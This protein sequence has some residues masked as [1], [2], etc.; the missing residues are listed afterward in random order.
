MYQKSDTNFLHP[1]LV[2]LTTQLFQ[3]IIESKINAP[4]FKCLG[5]QSIDYEQKANQI[6]VVLQFDIISSTSTSSPSLSSDN[7]VMNDSYTVCN[8]TDLLKKSSDDSRGEERKSPL[9]TIVVCCC[10]LTTFFLLVLFL[11]CRSFIRRKQLMRR[12]NN[13]KYLYCSN[14]SKPRPINHSYIKT[15]KTYHWSPPKPNHN[16]SFPAWFE[17]PPLKNNNNNNNYTTSSSSSL[18]HSNNTIKCLQHRIPYGSNH[19]TTSFYT[20]RQCSSSNDI[21]NS[22]YIKYNCQHQK[23]MIGSG[24]YLAAG[25][26]EYYKR[27]NNYKSVKNRS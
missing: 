8:Y 24:N 9:V 10:I 1:A 15:D 22:N 19:S 5:L 25:Y 23:C 21:I 3:D 2:N 4:N 14:Y 7:S 18:N 6:E 26:S 11:R 17:C 20:Q 12:R 13:S 27:M 16:N